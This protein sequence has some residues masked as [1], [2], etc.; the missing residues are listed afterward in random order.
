MV[1]GVRCTH[2]SCSSAVSRGR[3]YVIREL[4]RHL[5]PATGRHE[6]SAMLDLLG[7]IPRHFGLFCCIYR[8]WL[9]ER[10]QTVTREVLCRH[11]GRQP[12][13]P[14]PKILVSQVAHDHGRSIT[15]SNILQ[16]V[17][18]CH[19]VDSSLSNLPTACSLAHTRDSPLERLQSSSDTLGLFRDPSL[20]KARRHLLTTVESTL[21]NPTD[22]RTILIGSCITF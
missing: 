10:A 21:Q 17:W 20:H 6:L 15:A 22:Y 16:A 8:N 2:T 18:Y 9:V 12:T 4:Y 5:A 1:F 7:N 19:K 13:P 11:A 14:G 3:A